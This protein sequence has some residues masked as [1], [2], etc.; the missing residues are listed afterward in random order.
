MTATEGKGGGRKGRGLAP[1]SEKPLFDSLTRKRGEKRKKE[2]ADK[3]F[4]DSLSDFD[5]R[6]RKRREERGGEKGCCL[7]QGITP[8]VTFVDRE[9]RRKKGEWRDSATSFCSVKG[10]LS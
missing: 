10:G 8:S 4:P 6:G 3:A 2:V 9:R 7:T 1:F 5:E